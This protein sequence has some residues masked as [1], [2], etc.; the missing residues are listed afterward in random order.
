MNRIVTVAFSA[1]LLVSGA[2]VGLAAEDPATVTGSSTQAATSNMSDSQIRD[3]LAVEGYTVQRL[4]HEGDRVSVT[5]TNSI[6]GTTK[7]LVDA[8]TGQVTQAADDDDDDDDD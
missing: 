4:K 2:V 8:Q 1:A 5:A 6:G 7:L 3:Q